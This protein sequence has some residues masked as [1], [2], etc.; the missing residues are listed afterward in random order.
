MNGIYVLIGGNMG[1]R[2]NYLFWAKHEIEEKIGR[3][4]NHSS[5]YETA[6]WGNVLQ[7]PYLNQVLQVES[8]FSPNQLLEELLK[9]E[10][11]AGRVR[12]Q[13]WE[14]RVLDLDILFYYNEVII[15]EH[16]M[17]PH[18]HIADR[19]FVLSPL[20]EI[21]GEEIHPLTL[22]TIREMLKRCPDKLDVQLYNE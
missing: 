18:P 11:R 1:D 16:L 10:Q 5:V 21:A 13:K 20:S 14:E 4:I 19:R 8:D 9:I 12:H 3:I 6:A 22:L 7:A 15:A 2:L 17:I